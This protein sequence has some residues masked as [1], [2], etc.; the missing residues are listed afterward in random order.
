[1]CV[2]WFSQPNTHRT[3]DVR[4]ALDEVPVVWIEGSGANSDQDL[5][6][7]RSRLFDLLQLEIGYA[8]IAVNDSFHRIRRSSGMATVVRRSPV[9][10]EP[11]QECEEQ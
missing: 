2:F 7:I 8:V 6:V 1:M 3:H 11:C 9:G 4:R 5:I 10:D